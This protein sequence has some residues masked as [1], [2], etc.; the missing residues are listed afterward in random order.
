MHLFQAQNVPKSTLNEALPQISQ[1]GPGR[2]V[3]AA[4][5]PLAGHQHLRFKLSTY[6]APYKCLW[7]LSLDPRE[8]GKKRGRG[9]GTRNE[10]RAKWQKAEEREW[11][12]SRGIPNVWNVLTPLEHIPYTFRRNII[13]ANYAD[14]N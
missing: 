10:E 3:L 6:G 1:T 12:D 13:W 2:T 7:H 8:R 11:E 14:R 4:L 5:R 9:E